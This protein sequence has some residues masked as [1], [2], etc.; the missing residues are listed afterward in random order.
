MRIIGISC[1]YHDSAVAYIENSKIICAAQEE[2][3]SRKKHDPNFPINSFMWILDEYNLD[4][5]DIDYIAFYEDPKL[6][7]KRIK[8]T[9]SLNWP[10]S[11]KNYISDM[12]SQEFKINLKNYIRKKFNFKGKFYF[13]K[14]HISHA[15][16]AFY[17]S[18]F[19]SAA[20][21]TID[22]VGEYETTTF[23]LGTKD[24]LSI[25]KRIHFPHS[26]GLIYSA[27]TYYCGFKVNSGEYKLMGLAPYGKPIFKELILKNLIDVKKD[28]SFRLQM[29][30]F[31]HLGGD[32]AI[33]KEFEKLFDNPRRRPETDINQFYMNIAAS[34]QV[35]IEEVF[36]QICKYVKSETKMDN[37][38]LA[39]GVALNCVANGKLLK[40]GIF[41]NIWIQPA[42]GDAGGALGAALYCANKLDLKNVSVNYMN[43]YLGPAFSDQ[44][45]KIY[46]EKNKINYV[47]SDD[48]AFETA[49][50]IRDG[51]IIGW[52]QGNSEFGPRAL[53]NRSILG[54]PMIKNM[55]KEIN[56]KVKYRESFRPFAP[57]VLEEYA[58][59]WFD[60][61]V[62]SPY[63]LLVTNINKS[64]LIGTYNNR[65]YNFE[66]LSIKRSLIPAVTHVDCS[67]RIQTVSEKQNSLLSKL[68]YHFNKFTGCP[69]LINTS[70]NVR[71][72][73]I[74]LT[75]NDA[76]RCFMMT[77]IDY[78]AMGNYLIS[79]KQDFY[80]QA[81]K[82][83]DEYSKIYPLD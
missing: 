34:I 37:L 18:P 50:L 30:Y 74:V 13:C 19:S 20:F 23:G 7:L 81:E 38:C 52:F 17:P 71:G 9:H 11:Y 35:V 5:N 40:S 45:I 75:P 77:Q 57:V 36:L 76:F 58:H 66:D 25:K 80:K 70:F 83:S 62:N 49:S 44:D 55:Q 79:K 46:L 43:P 1:W 27:F 16:S 33:T 8:Y 63:M 54:N 6:K 24:N 21:L 26:L 29:K 31:G 61:N 10:N 78:L 32:K 72:E 42:S 82:L 47:K 53:G 56:M 14:H 65:N 51:K 22:G 67:A 41:K 28:G 73:P 59:E 3:F 60:L 64:K 48:I 2:R 69:V 12:K 15:A 68:I 39:G 4:I